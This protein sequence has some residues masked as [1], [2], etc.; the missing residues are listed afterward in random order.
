[1][2]AAIVLVVVLAIVLGGPVYFMITGRNRGVWNKRPRHPFTI[3]VRERYLDSTGQG[4]SRF[5]EY[6]EGQPL[7]G[8]RRRSKR[9]K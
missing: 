5:Q 7:E 3:P 2:I 1:M 8:N 6:D 4:E 9:D